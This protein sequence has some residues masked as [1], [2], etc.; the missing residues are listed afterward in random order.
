[1]IFITRILRKVQNQDIRTITPTLQATEE[2]RAYC[3]AY[4]PRTL[5]TENCS[6]W[7]N[8]GIK[9]GRVLA[10]WPGSGLHANN[11]RREPRWEDWEYTYRSESGNRFAYF[12]NG[13][14]KDIEL[15]QQALEAGGR[16]EIDMTP[17]L[18]VDSVTGKLDL[19]D[20]HEKWYNA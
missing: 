20:Y 15:D 13:W 11:V 6:S 7:Y 3:E 1:M 4:F 19:R 14:T 2:F 16:N 18:H 5:A 17:Y 12:G 8:G 10:M 9:G